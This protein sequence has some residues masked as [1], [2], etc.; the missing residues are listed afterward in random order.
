[1]VFRL[2]AIFLVFLLSVAAFANDLCVHIMQAMGES[3]IY[4]SQSDP[5]LGPLL[6]TGPGAGL[7]GPACALNVVQM[8]RK[9]SGRA[10]VPPSVLRLEEARVLVRHLSEFRGADARRG[11][12]VKQMREA[13][14]FLIERHRLPLE[15]AA[16]VDARSGPPLTASALRGEAA[17][18]WL[19][20]VHDDINADRDLNHWLVGVYNPM[21]EKM[22][23]LDPN[24]PEEPFYLEIGDGTLNGGRIPIAVIPADDRRAS[25]I[26]GK[27]VVRDGIGL[28]FTVPTENTAPVA[29]AVKT[30][31]SGPPPTR[32]EVRP[33]A[34]VAESEVN[35]IHTADRSAEPE[36]TYSQ[37]MQAFR[38][39][40]AFDFDM[41]FRADRRTLRYAVGPRAGEPVDLAQVER[42]RME[43]ARIYGGLG[44]WDR[45]NITY[46]VD[47]FERKI[48]ELGFN[49]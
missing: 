30:A 37:I 36:W 1:M 32:S 16:S 43:L 12:D 34:R 9:V 20:S 22:K 29:E 47:S 23:V 44:E 6:V 48:R 45:R 31:K 5:Q 35:F 11:T 2:P 3:P 38:A 25:Y 7:C 27:L 14:R 21:R 46:R 28:R 15:I 8:T 13:F 42:I 18:F 17:D 26:R 10:T 39:E 41:S 40:S 19:F 33:D 4:L 24:T 49:P